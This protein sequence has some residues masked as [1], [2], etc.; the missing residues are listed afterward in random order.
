MKRIWASV[1]VVGILIVLAL[2]IP[3]AS[4]TTSQAFQKFAVW[5]PPYDGRIG[6]S[7]QVEIDLNLTSGT[8][9]FG[10]GI[11][12]N[13]S[14]AGGVFAPGF[15]GHLSNVTITF[16]GAKPYSSQPGSGV[17]VGGAPAVSGVVLY[18]ASS[19]YIHANGVI[20]SQPYLCGLSS[21]IVWQNAGT[22]S[23][24][25]TINFNNGTAPLT[26]NLTADIVTVVA[27]PPNVVIT[28]TFGS[29]TTQYVAVEGINWFDVFIGVVFLIGVVAVAVSVIFRKKLRK[30]RRIRKLLEILGAGH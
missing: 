24:F 4:S 12:V 22:Y 16:R 30:Y 26:E 10:F 2:S 17:E 1:A 6:F 18:P 8:S 11:P 19:C 14:A 7:N 9:V 23:P 25:L 27:P 29:A 5:Y 15:N 3:S 28:D 20:F 21:R 13:V